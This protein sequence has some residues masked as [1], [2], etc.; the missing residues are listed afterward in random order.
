M[1]KTVTFPFWLKDRVYKICPV[2]NAD[3]NGSCE[4]CAWQGCFS[5]GCEVGVSV[6]EDG[7]FTN[8]DL[9]VIERKVSEWNFFITLRWWN[10]MYFPTK[11]DAEK[12]L[13]EYVHIRSIVDRKERYKTYKEW[14]NEREWRYPEENPDLLPIKEAIK[15]FCWKEYGES[16]DFTD[17]NCVGL[18]YTE[19][20]CLES[21]DDE[22]DN[23]IKDLK[24]QVNADVLDLSIETFYNDILV[25]KI[26]FANSDE[27]ADFINGMSF[28]A[29]VAIDDD[30]K[31]EYGRKSN[32]N[33]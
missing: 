22:D 4:N 11:E 7:S 1:K 27:M 26:T 9:Q 5:P 12:A 31:K 10:I 2:C 15:N 30:L 24:I 19:Y 13:N 18:A 33:N 23:I 20:E 25:E 8:K 32:E 16:P 17:P 6:Y 14:E 21:N 28:D 3:H 29:L